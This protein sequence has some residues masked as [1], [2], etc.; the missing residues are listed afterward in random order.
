ML[1]IDFSKQAVVFLKSLQ[2]KDS[3]LISEKISHFRENQS[4]FS[5]VAIQ[6]HKPLRRIRVGNYRVVYYIENE[7][8]FIAFV[9]KRNDD[10]VYKLL[11]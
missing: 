3:F 2:K 4:T 9:W 5:S 8:L 1:N 11:K 10:E 6:G 7:T